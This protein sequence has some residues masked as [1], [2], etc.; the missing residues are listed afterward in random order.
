MK[1][2]RREINELVTLDTLCFTPPLNYSYEELAAYISPPDAILLRQYEGENIIAFCLGDASSGEI[3]TL[4]V[5]PRHRGKGIGKKLLS[6]MLDEFRK[7]DVRQA[8]SQVAIDN[9]PSIRL[10]QKLGFEIR[11]ILFDYYPDGSAAFE[12]VLSLKPSTK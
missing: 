2:T 10:H 12:L 9:L 6:A 8:I 1:L 7:R 5:H 4:D 3:I 11:C